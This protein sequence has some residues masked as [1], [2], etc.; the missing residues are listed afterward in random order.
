MRARMRVRQR[1]CRLQG[2]GALIRARWQG[3]RDDGDGVPLAGDEEGGPPQD[4][5]LDAET[6]LEKNAIAVTIDRAAGRRNSKQSSVIIATW[7]AG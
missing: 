6:G 1:L 4:Y 3:K 5:Y 2:Q 7:V